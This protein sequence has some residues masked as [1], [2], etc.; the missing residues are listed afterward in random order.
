[1]AKWPQQ[2]PLR[3]LF[4]EE[5]ERVLFHPLSSRFLKESHFWGGSCGGQF[6][7][8]GPK[9]ALGS[10]N[11]VEE[12]AEVSEEIWRFL[13]KFREPTLSNL[14]HPARLFLNPA[15]R[16]RPSTTESCK[17][18]LIS[19]W[20]KVL[21]VCELK[22]KFSRQSRYVWTSIYALIHIFQISVSHMKASFFSF[23]TQ[24]SQKSCFP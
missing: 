20:T 3:L 14:F 10:Q 22:Y 17:T 2:N 15:T 21:K 1:M 11:N 23:T 6:G 13:K 5:V 18:L 24:G 7:H 16:W 4:S 9:G 12:V 19:T 8:F